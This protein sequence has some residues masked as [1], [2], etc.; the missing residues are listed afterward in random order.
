LRFL[1]CVQTHRH[2]H[3]QKDSSEQMI[4]LSHTQLLIWHNKHKGQTS[5]SSVECEPTIPAIKHLQT[6]V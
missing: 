1:D 3:T 2:T 6:Y 4:S 5:M